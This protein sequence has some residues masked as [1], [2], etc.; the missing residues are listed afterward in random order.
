[1]LG[2][3][4]DFRYELGFEKGVLKTVTER[5][6]KKGSVTGGRTADDCTDW[7]YQTWA[8]WSDGSMTL[9]GE[10]YIGTT[11]DSDCALAKT[12]NGKSSRMECSGNGGGGDIDYKCVEEA[13]NNFNNTLTQSTTVS[14]KIITRISD[15]D[16]FTKHKDPVWKCFKGFGGWQLNSQEIGVIKLVDVPNNIWNWVSLEHGGMS[17]TGSPLPGASVSFSQGIGT[18]SI[19]TLYAGMSLNFTVT[20]SFVCNCPNIPLLGWIPPE[21]KTYTSTN[22][23]DAK[24]F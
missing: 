24:P 17:M 14:E 7:Y 13:T 5:K 19:S 11:C 22:I 4:D 8:V 2:A 12:V 15:I 1:M 9:I 20:Y 21:N 23:W 18:P 10:T 6:S 16:Q 3:A